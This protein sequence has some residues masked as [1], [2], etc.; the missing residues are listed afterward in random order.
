MFIF[1]QVVIVDLVNLAVLFSNCYA[2]TY[3]GDIL[4]QVNIFMNLFYFI[5]LTNLFLIKFLFLYKHQ[6]QM[7]LIQI[8][9]ILLLLLLSQI[10]FDT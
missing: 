4:F 3:I 5:I 6:T 9:P 10:L 8:I 1:L 7:N 2:F